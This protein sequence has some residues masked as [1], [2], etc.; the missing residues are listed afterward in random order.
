MGL[1]NKLK[2]FY[3]KK[4][5]VSTEN[6]NLRDGTLSMQEGQGEGGGFY[7]FFK[8]NFIAQ[9]TIGLNISWPSNFFRKYFMG[10]LINFSFLFKTYLQ[11][12]FRVVLTVILKFQIAKEVNI[13][14][15]IQKT[16]F[17]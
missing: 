2:S 9:E 14:S 17:K 3:N 13:H 15:N 16:I 12:Y 8:Q 7:K 11:Q 4:V 10:P 1:Y 6:M 5:T